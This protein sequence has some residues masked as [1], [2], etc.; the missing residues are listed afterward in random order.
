MFNSKKSPMKVGKPSSVAPANIKSWSNPFDSD[1]EE[2]DNRKYNSS[3]KTSSQRPL[4]TLEVNTNP[5]DDI[6]DNKHSSS[7]SSSSSYVRQSADRNRYKNNFRDSGGLENQSVQELENY[8]VHKAEE[9]TNSIH[10][11]L[12]IAETIRENATKTLVTLHQQGDQIT[13]SHQVAA[14]IE[15]D[16]SRV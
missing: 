11:C 4:V 3:K 6:D 8:A 7:S 13:R 5:F 2:K 1:D 14:D 15:Q 16:L 10:N 12:K 9:A